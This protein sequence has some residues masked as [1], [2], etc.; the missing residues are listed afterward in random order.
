MALHPK[1]GI[2]IPGFVKT[3]YFTSASANESYKTPLVVAL[4]FWLVSSFPVLV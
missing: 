3:A 4:D 2:E 1:R